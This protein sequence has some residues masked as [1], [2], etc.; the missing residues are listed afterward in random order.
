MSYRTTSNQ[1]G[2]LS[3][4]IFYA[5]MIRKGWMVLTPSSR[6]AIYDFVVDMAEDGFVKVQVKTLQ[7]NTINKV[8]D[9]S[10]SKV[11]NNG[12]ERNSTDYAEHG[13]DWLV[14]VDVNKS[15]CYYYSLNLYSSISGKSIN[16]KDLPSQEFP[17]NENVISNRTGKKMTI[18]PLEGERSTLNSFLET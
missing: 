9:R 7:K 11:S 5:E 17:I 13:I 18:P 10:S 16:V 1:T 12:K 14:A 8:V 6:D 3:E 15:K 4:Q 2:D